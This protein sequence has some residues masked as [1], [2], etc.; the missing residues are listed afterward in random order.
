M[1]LLGEGWG[2]IPNIFQIL[3]GL[4]MSFLFPPFIG[5][6]EGEVKP[7]DI[8]QCFQKDEVEEI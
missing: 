1:T 6:R 3:Q 8:I 5:K 2:G 4:K 7:R